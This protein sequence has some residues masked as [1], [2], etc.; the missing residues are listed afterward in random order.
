MKENTRELCLDALLVALVTICTMV[1]Q[2][3]VAGTS[4]YIH[5]GDSM[6]LLIGL[7]FGRKRGAIAGGVG[8]ALAD[9][10]SGYAHWV[11]FTLIIKALMGWLVGA[12]CDFQGDGSKLF[13]LRNGVAVL[14]AEVWMVIGYLLGGAVL[15]S[16]FAVALT[17]VPE[18]CV[19]AIGG[20]LVFSVLAVAFCRAKIYRFVTRG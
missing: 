5:L 15:K 3:P 2:I 11:V 20:I 4:G 17:S 14:L 8:S 18:N 12:V 16:S 13:T 19:Q 6:I 1:I 7:F 10:L 9:F